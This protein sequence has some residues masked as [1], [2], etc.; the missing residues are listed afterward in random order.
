MNG[1]PSSALGVL[2]GTPK[3]GSV[4]E[5]S[6]ASAYANDVVLDTGRYAKGVARAATRLSECQS[7]GVTKITAKLDGTLAV[8]AVQLEQSAGDAKRALNSYA[9]EVDRIHSKADLLVQEVNDALV[10]IRL[11]MSE[12]D[13]IAH[14]IQ[15]GREHSWRNAPPGVMPEPEPVGAESVSD[16]ERQAAVRTLQSLYEYSWLLGCT[17]WRHGLQAVSH[18]ERA[19]EVLIEEREAAERRLVATLGHTGIGELIRFAEASGRPRKLAVSIGIAGELWGSSLGVPGLSRSHE[20]LIKLIGAESGAHIWTDPPPPE[21]VAAAWSG[22]LSENERQRLIAE[23]PW[24][25][26]NLPGIPFRDRDAANRNLISIYGSL[27]GLLSVRSVRALDELIRIIGIDEDPPVQVVALD[28]G[29]DVPAVAVGYGGLDTA[30]SVT[31]QAPGM[32]NDADQALVGWDRASRN[33]YWEQ[34]SLG[35]ESN[36]VIAFLGYDT[37]DLVDSIAVNDSLNVGE[38]GVLSANLAR[39]GATRF[40]AELDGTWATRNT[41]L[42]VAPGFIAAGSPHISV[43]AHSYGTT[44]AANALTL[45]RHPV[46]SLTMAGS[47]GI[48]EGWVASLKQLN[49]AGSEHGVPAIYAS[50]ASDD[51][52]AP[53]G[54]TFSGRANPNP[55]LNYELVS[56]Y[57]GALHY[58]SDGYT[59]P[60]GDVFKRTDGHSALGAEDDGFAHLVKHGVGFEASLGHG[61]WD[62]ATQSLR[63]MAATSIGRPDKVV[64][65]IFATP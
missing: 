55:N 51:G 9:A 34:A 23:A 5:I 20:L 36:A 28:L 49:V 56:N 54:V 62:E 11:A 26:G 43:V 6:A 45:V 21:Q 39:Q 13:S 52:L 15:Y 42:G 37:P 30:A 48:D 24:V 16:A 57:G 14:V 2:H 3:A 41:P 44:M 18:A 61:Y 4:A 65:G 10:Q 35:T 40:A 32:E 50:H 46:G 60:N 17:R 64:G 58:S 38:E 59:A 25:I 8:G 31:W 22:S 29:R 7:L 19:W 53:V 47:A 63:N 1:P 12:I 33:L 27:R